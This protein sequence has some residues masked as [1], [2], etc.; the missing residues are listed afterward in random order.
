MKMKKLLVLG[1]IL[2]FIGVAVAPSINFTVVKASN[3]NDLVE[4]T[5][6]ACGIQGFGN[7]TVKLTREQADELNQLFETINS[8]LNNA[9]SREESVRIYHNVIIELDRYGLLPRGMTVEQAQKL[10]ANGYSKGQGVSIFEEISHKNSL[11]EEPN[12]FCCLVAGVAQDGTAMGILGMIG[13]VPTFR[14]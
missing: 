12:N 14:T 4:V 5:T 11:Q 6:Q 1:V 2:L 7:T 10:V 9:T 8:K 3:D 13:L